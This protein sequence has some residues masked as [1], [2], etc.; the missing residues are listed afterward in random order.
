LQVA[1]VAGL[2]TAGGAY[3]PA[4]CDQTI[5]IKEQGAIFIGGRR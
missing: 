5:I 4:M 2:S 3:V 1:L